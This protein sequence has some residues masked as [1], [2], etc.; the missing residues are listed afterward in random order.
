M[1]DDK[2]TVLTPAHYQHILDL[3]G[4]EH[5]ALREVRE[6]TAGLPDAVMQIAPDQARFMQLQLVL[7][8]ARRVL[9]IGTY[10]GY[11]ALAMALVLPCD[12]RVT[13]LDVNTENLSHARRF[14][15]RAGVL[16]RIETRPGE[17]HRTLARMMEAEHL[18]G[19]YDAAFIDADKART[20]LYFERCYDLVRPG[21]LIMIDNTFRH[22]AVLD[23]EEKWD[24][25][26]R[27]I[28]E[29]GR[30][31]A[32]DERLLVSTVAVGDGLT[33]ALKSGTGE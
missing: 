29:T 11:S 32:S 16:D 1:A 12:G 27:A 28:V 30:K 7:M 5:P 21:G 33:L 2:Y 6:F 18:S 17:A 10:T 20:G 26:T 13:T 22:G 25:G 8:G 4:P 19:F 9:E 24:K 15:E 23:P 14:W 3:N 31:L